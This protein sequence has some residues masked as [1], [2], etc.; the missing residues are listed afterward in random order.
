LT[1]FIK[2]QEIPAIFT[3]TTAALLGGSS[4]TETQISTTTDTILLLRYVELFG[5]MRR[6]LAVLKMRGSAHEKAIREYTVDSNGMHVG[7]PFRNVGGILSG[8]YILVDSGGAGREGTGGAL[9]VV[10][11]GLSE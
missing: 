3:S 2:Y 6:G 10:S 1:S 7:D 11:S 9:A 5:E 8:Q 4:I